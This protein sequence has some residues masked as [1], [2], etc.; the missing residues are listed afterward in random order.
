M[1]DKP[2]TRPCMLCRK[3]FQPK[4]R[5]RHWY[6]KGCRAKVG[7]SPGLRECRD[8]KDVEPPRDVSGGSYLDL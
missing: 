3:P 6:C 2:F 4:D 5:K 1:E 7:S 8:P